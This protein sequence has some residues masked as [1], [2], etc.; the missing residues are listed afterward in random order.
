MNCSRER[1]VRTINRQVLYAPVRCCCFSV[2]HGV[3]FFC[4]CPACAFCLLE[5]DAGRSSI[6]ELISHLD[7]K[8]GVQLLAW[9]G[10]RVHKRLLSFDALRL[11]MFTIFVY[12]CLFVCFV[13]SLPPSAERRCDHAHVQD[14]RS[15]FQ[16]GVQ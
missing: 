12:A 11:R 15:T 13:L 7:M 5:L 6:E 10:V 3:L 9:M 8:V 14:H 16:C 1:K 4:R 2:A